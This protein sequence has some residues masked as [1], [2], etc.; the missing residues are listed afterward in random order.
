V[1]GLLY[2]ELDSYP[3]CIIFAYWRCMRTSV[4]W[5]LYPGCRVVQGLLLF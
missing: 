1:I 5:Q 2:I 3:I 4:P